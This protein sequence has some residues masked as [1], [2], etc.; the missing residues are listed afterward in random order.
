VLSMRRAKAVKA[1]LEDMGIDP[2]RIQVQGH[3]D[4]DPVAPN[5]SPENKLKNRRAV[6]HL[7]TADK[8]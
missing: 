3:S 5:D 8:K 4:K 7:S 1:H 6:M 2:K